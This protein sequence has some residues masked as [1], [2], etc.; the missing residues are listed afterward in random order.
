MAGDNG[1]FLIYIL[2]SI[3]R[4]HERYLKMFVERIRNY[5]RYRQTMKELQG[6]SDRE[7]ND[8]GIS[9]SEIPHVAR[10]TF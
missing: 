9:R 7:L 6:L 1:H 3:Y 5:R 4:E 8:I 10:K 2:V